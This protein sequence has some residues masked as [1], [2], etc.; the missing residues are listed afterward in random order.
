MKPNNSP[1]PRNRRILSIAAVVCGFAMT[2]QAALIAHYKFD[3]G[4]GATS[5]A[6]ELGGTAGVIG[7]NV[8]TGATGISGNAYQF[9]NDASDN[10]IVSM[11]NASFLSQITT[12]NQYTFSAWIKT[13]DI[14]GNRNTAVFAGANANNVYADLGLTNELVAGVPRGE[15]SARNRPSTANSAQQ[16]GVFSTGVKVNDDTWHHL[17]MTVDLSTSLMSLYVDGALANTQAATVIPTFVQF[18]V[19]RLGRVTQTK[20]DPFDGLI[21]D[22]QVY[23]H[24]LSQSEVQFLFNNPG[25]AVPEPGSLVLAGIGLLSLARR[26]RA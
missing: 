13:A 24:A 17:V 8:T 14:S 5:A 6:E 1:K 26:R 20:V 2:S 19:G 23:N 7:T 16:T 11:G 22:V 25:T 18:E 10:G 15:A 4:V 21:D 9:G 12:S 3:E